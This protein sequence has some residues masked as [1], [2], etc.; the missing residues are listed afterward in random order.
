VCSRFV[1]YHEHI[2]RDPNVC[3]G[4]RRDRIIGADATNQGNVFSWDGPARAARTAWRDSGALW[5]NRAKVRSS[6]SALSA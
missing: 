5:D 6:N 2:H 4:S 3:G 1:T